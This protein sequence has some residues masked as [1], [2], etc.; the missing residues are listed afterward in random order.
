[1]GEAEIL[2]FCFGGYPGANRH[3]REVRDATGLLRHIVTS[4]GDAASI[5]GKFFREEIKARRPRLVIFGGW[6]RSYDALLDTALAAGAEGAVLWTSSA[7]QTEL[8]GETPILASLL[9]D[10]RIGRYFA[11][12]ASML[13]VLAA[14][15]RPA[16]HLPQP[17][18]IDAVAPR[19]RDGVP[20]EPPIVSLFCAPAEYRRKNAFSC[21]AALGAVDAPYVLHLNGLSQ[22]AEYSSLLAQREI[23]HHDHGWMDDTGYARA[24]D[25]VDLG[26][27]VSLAD[28]FNYVVAEHF[29]RAIPVL[30]SPMVPCAHG[31]PLEVARMLVVANPDDPVEIRTKLRRLLMGA[32]ERRE[33]GDIVQRHIVRVAASNGETSRRALLAAV[34]RGG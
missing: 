17:L 18:R 29:L 28:S 21:I 32:A 20:P 6:H 34:G 26:L 2:S 13:D 5:E 19:K 25:G 31:L 22:R 3:L 15:G 9:S 27:Q 23:P 10:S 11:A 33:L 4:A 24:L 16:H 7:V 1:M 12:S 8:S 14:S 30:V